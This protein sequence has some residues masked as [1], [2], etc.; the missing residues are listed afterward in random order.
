MPGLIDSIMGLAGPQILN[1]L[2]SRLGENESAVKG[3]LQSG[4]AAILGSI[5]SKAGDGNAMGQI[6][7]LL[8]GSASQGILGNISSLAASGP[9]GA[10]SD[11]S[12]KLLGSL[13][14]SGQ[15]DAIGAI[16]KSSGLSTGAATSVM[17]MAAPLVMGFLGNKVKNEGLSAASLGSLLTAELPA[18]KSLL[19]A[20]LGSIATGLGSVMAAGA[21]SGSSAISSTVSA[22]SAAARGAASAA[23]SE[24]ESASSSK[25]LVPLLL[26]AAALAGLFWFFSQGSSSVP[27]PSVPVAA[28]KD[29]VKDAGKAA[30]GAATGILAALG[31][32]F[33]RKLPNGVELNIPQMGVE[34]KLISFIEDAAKPVDK[35]TWFNFDRLL[36]DTGAATLQ[37]SSQEQLS[38][39][40]AILKAYPN[41]EIKLGGYTDN[42][43]DKAANKKLS[44]DRATN[45]MNELVK[46]GVPAKRLAA[47]GYGD[48]HPAASNDTEEG[49]QQNRRIAMRVTKK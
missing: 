10:V 4:L 37:A 22:G 19:P 48:E 2:A 31:E 30:T 26:A 33:K 17:G 18:I 27:T 12:Q 3:G 42:T 29:A 1:A 44:G 8:T 15:N 9:S 35:T 40:A 6:F 11:M 38:N 13:F 23:A 43:G 46:L 14:G 41:V 7:S 45:V 5:A 32:F 47:E 24:V 36:F 16:A 20:G 25:W 39:I 49:R 34:N 28:V 21:A